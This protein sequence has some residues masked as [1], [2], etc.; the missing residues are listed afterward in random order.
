MAE[1]K[2]S[3]E[4]KIALLTQN[5]QASRREMV[6]LESLLTAHPALA[7]ESGGQGELEKCT[8]LVHWLESAGITALQRF[9]APD[10]R[11]ASGIRPNLIATIPGKDDSRTVWI[12]SHLDVVPEGERSL[13]QTDPWTV[14]EKEGR[15]YGRGVEDNQQGLTASVFA[16]L[17]FLRTGIKPANTVK[18]LFAADEEVGS[19]YGI[20]FLLDNYSLF[21]PQDIII[22]PDGGDSDGETIE[23]A[24]KNLLWLRLHTSGKQ[25]HGSR[26]D[27]GANACLAGCDLALRLHDLENFFAKKDSLFEPPCSTF[28]PTKKEANVPNINTIPGDDVICM[29]CRILPCYTLDEVRTEVKKRIAEVERKHGVTISWTEEQAVESP[30]TPVT[31]AVVS[32][33]SEA[34]KKV[35]GRTARP[36]GIGGGTVGA[37]LR[38]TGLQAAVWGKLDETAHQPNEYCILDNLIGDAEVLALVMLGGE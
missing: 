3:R 23:V 11:V 13:W 10:S 30:A 24:E 25:A 5:I 9:D 4:E 21:R 17:A 12:M 1:K 16:A 8:A 20:Q 18:L 27:E 33:L 14:T 28:Q 38:R 26:P 19:A 29:D 7:P 36:V 2:Q 32:E 37:Y 6:T 35:Y 31:A 15:I 22:I 34:I